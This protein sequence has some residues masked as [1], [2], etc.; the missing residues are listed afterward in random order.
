MTHKTA[1]ATSHL[2]LL[3]RLDALLVNE[4]HA[5]GMSYDGAGGGR[6]DAWAGGA[7]TVAET[8]TITATSSTSFD[9]VGSVSGA[10]GAATV[11]TTFTTPQVT[12]RIVA[13]GAAFA[14]GDEFTLTMTPPWTRRRMAGCRG[15]LGRTGDWTNIQSLYDLSNGTKA[16]KAAVPAIAAMQLFR[17]SE[18]Q[19]IRVTASDYPARAPTTL[20]LERSSNGSSWTAVETWAGLVWDSQHESKILSVGAAP[21]AYLHWRVRATVAGAENPV[22]LAGLAFLPTGDAGWSLEQRIEFAWE[23]PGPDGVRKC[24]VGGFVYEDAGADTY[25]LGL[26][27]FRAWDAG[28]RVTDQLNACTPK[29]VGLWNGSTPVWLY[30]NGQRMAF[31][32]KVSTVYHPGYAGFGLPYGTPTEHP[33]PLVVGGSGDLIT[34]RWSSDAVEVRSFSDPGRYGLTAMMPDNS[35]REFANRYSTSGSSDDGQPDVDPQVGKV[36]PAAQGIGYNETAT[37]Q[38]IDGTI[39][40]KPVELTILDPSHPW[41][42]LDGVFW[43]SGFGGNGAENIVT[44]DGFRHTV[45]QNIGRTQPHHYYAMR[46]D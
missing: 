8:I 43:C 31:V 42:E 21:G 20:V 37:R 13:A 17:E 2:D 36:L 5:W 27:G 29:V 3:T 19:A 38:A 26:V 41:G 1:T 30:A 14:A 16:T 45:F 24:L 15:A 35:W 22:E 11:G 33:H 32:A 9:V 7:S 44:F 23:S 18:V 46:I 34:R 40:V 39:G 28:I 4:G 10:L 25:N 12:F 6:L